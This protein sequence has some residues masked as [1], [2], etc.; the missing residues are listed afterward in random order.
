MALFVDL[1]EDEPPHDFAG[2]HPVWTGEGSCRSGSELANKRVGAAA[3]VVNRNGGADR[4]EAHEPAPAENPNRN[5]LMTVALG[6][7][8][9]IKV[10]ASSIDLNTLDSLSRTCRQ[11]RANLLQHRKILINTTLRCYRED[12]MADDGHRSYFRTA[13]GEMRYAVL[14]RAGQ[15]RECARDK[16][17]E[18]RRCDTVICR[19]CIVKPPASNMLRQRHRR[20]CTG[21]TEAPIAELANPPL[22]S[23]T[24]LEAEILQQAIC[25]CDRDITWLCT[26]CGRGLRA[27]DL[28]YQAIW[29]W[30]NQYGDCW[31][32]L[33]T[34][35]GDGDRGVKCAREEACHSA[36]EIEQET[37]CDAEDAREAEE[38]AHRIPLPGSSNSSSSIYQLRSSSPAQPQLYTTPRRS[39]MNLGLPSPAPSEGSEHSTGPQGPGYE[40]HEVEGIGGVVKKLRVHMVKV[41]GCV[42]EWQDEMV[43]GETLGREISGR[44]RSWCG[45]CHRVIPAKDDYAVKSP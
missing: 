10:V 17:S 20:L 34:G 1:D 8:P 33:G 9:I 21:C 42:P 30:R 40:R 29:R 7:Y 11:I 23:E 26:G 32:G 38:V 25:H 36:K 43:K 13:S 18:C 19:N 31:G 27:A 4:E 5:S 6:C 24:P 45:W 37:D 41:G 22:R 44:V 15:L 3:V 28:D 14:R 35:I 39:S 16:V 2:K 12:P